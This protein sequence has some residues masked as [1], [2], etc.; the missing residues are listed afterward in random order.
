MR[1]TPR[2]AIIGAGMSG[3][4]MAAKLQNAGIESFTVYEEAHEVG[5]TWRDNAY[6][7]LSC[8]V[9]SQFYSYSFHPNPSW[10]QTFASGPDILRYFRRV[11]DERGL[12]RHIRF[13]SRVQS[14]RYEDGRWRLTTGD[15]DHEIVDVVVT[16]TGFLRIPRYPDFP[17][18]TSFAGK[19]FHSARW[20]HSVP[21]ADKRI[22]VIGN[23][24]SGVQIVT[25]LGG[26][27]AQL[28]LFQR[29]P[30]WIFPMPNR[31]YTRLGR[32]MLERSARLNSVCYRL[33]QVIY[34]GGFAAA[35]VEPGWR[36]R[37]I[38]A[39]CR[40]HLRRVR[41]P[42]LRRQLTPDYQAM[43]KRLVMSAGFYPAMQKPNVRL[44]TDAIEHVEPA[45]VVTADGALH[46]LDVLVM[47]TG[48][49]AHAYIRPMQLYGENGISLEDVWA[50]GP[51]AYRTVAVPGFPNLFMLVGPH[52]PVGHQSVIRIAEE[53][54]GYVMWWISQLWEGRVAAAAPT[55]AAT[56]RF[57]ADMKAAMPQTVWTTG[58]RSWYLD[59]DGL[60]ELFPWRPARYRE[61]LSKPDIAD[62]DVVP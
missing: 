36:R 12:R 60:P 20:D 54:A 16:A 5:G 29:T 41:D 21:L 11:V 45:G 25:E 17:G 52:S 24:S 53:Q 49:D 1:A 61:L 4:C 34:E 26:N 50:D 46:E 51:R 56:E 6:P 55:A 35:L 23:G 47:A 33:W 8:D 9:P 39:A 37:F 43:C 19:V 57:N 2:V 13:N 27:V 44:V 28:T 18:L 42:V 14:A 40:W 15:G 48:F 30:Q 7:G 31:R 59:K 10:S 3:L 22:G 38:S 58:C 32:V 62:F